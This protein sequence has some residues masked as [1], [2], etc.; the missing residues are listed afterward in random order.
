MEQQIEEMNSWRLYG[1]VLGNRISIELPEDSNLQ[2][3]E[4][5]IIPRKG[6][7]VSQK[8]TRR[9]EWKKD[10]LKISQWDISEDE[11]RMKS[12]PIPEF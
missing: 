2:E 6:K 7:T 12:W 5:I 4:I 3:V 1:K 9:E 11:I 8:E 10:F